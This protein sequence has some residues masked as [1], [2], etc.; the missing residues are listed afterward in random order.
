[1]KEQPFRTGVGLKYSI[2]GEPDGVEFF[3]GLGRGCLIVF[4]TLSTFPYYNFFFASLTKIPPQ[5]LGLPPVSLQKVSLQKQ[6]ASLRQVDTSQVGM[7]GGGGYSGWL[8]EGAQQCG[9]RTAYSEEYTHKCS[10][11]CDVY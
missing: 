11:T 4:Q 10:H 3:P 1:M 8:D 5:R 2:V 9:Y 7:E 6:C